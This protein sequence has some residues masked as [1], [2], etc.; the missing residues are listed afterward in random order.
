MNYRKFFK[1]FFITALFVFMA[2]LFSYNCLCCCKNIN[3]RQEEDNIEVRQEDIGT[4]MEVNIIPTSFNES[5]K[6]QI[7]TEKA[8]IVM[9]GHATIPIGKKATIHFKK[10]GRK[11]ISWEN[12]EYKYLIY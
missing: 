8:S 1:Y 2:S 7:K 12:D 4:I 10:S 3:Q 9:I 5:T 11:Q 6:T